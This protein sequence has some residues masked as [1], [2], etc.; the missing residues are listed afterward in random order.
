MRVVAAVKN[1][2][3]LELNA[4][5]KV[6][7]IPVLKTSTIVACFLHNTTTSLDT[8]VE[9]KSSFIISTQGFM[10]YVPIMV[11]YI[12]PSSCPIISLRSNGNVVR[13]MLKTTDTC[14]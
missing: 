4:T 14:I 5:M 10:C 2:M 3:C 7:T 9:R 6:H 1:L 11:Y 13:R 8:L 12:L